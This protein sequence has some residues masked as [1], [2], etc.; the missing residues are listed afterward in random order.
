MTILPTVVIILIMLQLIS[1]LTVFFLSSPAFSET[2]MP[3]IKRY[4]YG[5]TFDYDYQ[6][7]KASAVLFEVRGWYLNY[8]DADIRGEKPFTIKGE[9][10]D[11]IEQK[12]TAVKV[13]SRVEATVELESIYWG[14]KHAPLVCKGNTEAGLDL[15]TMTFE[16][17]AFSFDEKCP[18][19]EIV[20][21]QLFT[22]AYGP[23]YWPPLEIEDSGGPE[24]LSKPQEVFYLDKVF[25][26]NKGFQQFNVHFQRISQKVPNDKIEL[27]L[28]GKISSSEGDIRAH[29]VMA[30]NWATS[31][32]M[33]KMN[34][35]YERKLI[36][37]QDVKKLSFLTFELTR[38]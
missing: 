6:K 25:E 7:L 3:G 1:I 26:L 10:K 4:D 30:M 31:V 22:L 35:Q 28:V 17:A 27:D 14:P 37:P 36:F 20:F 2:A 16:F 29:G 9:M 5:N 18:M 12:G 8:R 11:L 33:L 13:K 23:V 32:S 24:F 19:M 21:K 15:K 38:R 34:Y